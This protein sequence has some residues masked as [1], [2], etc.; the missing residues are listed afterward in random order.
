MRHGFTLIE[1]M[2]VVGIMAFLGTAAT[3]GYNAFQRGMAERGATGAASSLLK[4]AKERAMVDRQPTMVFC[5]NRLIREASGDDENAIAVGEAIAIRRAGRI[6]YA[7]DDLLADE[8]ADIVGSYDIVDSSDIQ[9]RG[10]IRLWQFDD[11]QMSDAKYSTIADAVEPLDGDVKLHTYEGWAFG[12]DATLGHDAN[13]DFGSTSPNGGQTKV[14]TRS[15]QMKS[16]V[17]AF[18]VLDP[19]SAS[20]KVGT[21]YGFEFAR[22]QLPH[23]FV[24][25][26]TIPT[27]LD[28]IEN[29]G[30]MYFDA[31]NN[32]SDKSI[33][34]YPCQVDGSGNLKL[35]QN[36][37]GTATSKGNTKI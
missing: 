13:I 26:G 37:A 1:L 19:G 10:G 12:E 18:H 7:S 14:I 28:R 24:F 29:A 4:A 27:Q 8:F 15:G 3:G 25:S 21:G 5:Y 16:L 32:S 23:N 6:T 2:V 20:W 33:D 17:Y 22:V 30:V 34:V 35:R 11:R 36:R 9:D 31:E